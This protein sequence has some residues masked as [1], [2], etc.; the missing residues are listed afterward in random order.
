M[1]FDKPQSRN[2]A[3]L[4]NMLGANNELEPPKSR[5]EALLQEIAGQMPEANPS[6]GTTTG[7]LERLKIG[8][9]I[10]T[11]EGG[12]SGTSDYDALNNKPQI[13]GVTLSGDKSLADLGIAS[14]STVSGILDGTDID[15]FG[16][17]E[18][19]L[20]DKVDKVNG[21]GLSTNDYDDTEKAAVSAATTAIAGIKDGT[22]IDS[23]GDVET[24]LGAIQ[25]GQSIDSFADVESAI[26]A[27]E[28]GTTIDSFADVENALANK[29]NATDNNLDTEAKTIVGAINEHEGDIGSLKSGLTDLSEEV[30]GDATVYPYADV[31]TIEDAVPSNLADCSVKIEPVQD[32]HGQSAPYVGGAGKNKLPLVLADIKAANTGG[33]WNDN[34]Y[35]INSG[36]ITVYTDD[37]GNVTGI[38]AN[39]TFNADSYIIIGTIYLDSSTYILNGCP[40]GGGWSTYLQFISGV[41]GNDYRDI[42]NGVSFNGDS[43]SHNAYIRVNAGTVS[44]LEFL[45]MIRLAT[46]TDATFAPYTNI[47]PI[48][49]HTEVDVQRSRL[50]MLDGLEQGFY[51]SVGSKMDADSQVRSSDYIDVTGG[52][53]YV[54]STD[55]VGLNVY[56]SQYS[57]KDT[58]RITGSNWQSLPYTFTTESNAKYIH[59]MFKKSDNN[60]LSPSEVVNPR[61]DTLS[62]YN[63]I[64]T[65][66]IALGD[67]IYGGTVDFDSGVMTVTQALVDMGMLSWVYD[68]HQRFYSTGISSTVKTPA[69][70]Q[71]V[72]NALCSDYPVVKMA[73]QDD[74][75]LTIATNGTLYVRDSAYTDASDFKTAMDG[76][77][78]CYELATPTTIQLTPQQIQL[79][80]GTNTLTAST[81]QISVT[82][83]G[84]SGAIG[85]V[86][87]QVNEI[88]ADVADVQSGLSNKIGY[89]RVDV[90]GT[91]I[92]SQE[93]GWYYANINLPTLPSG[94]VPISVYFDG[95]WDV[96][97]FYSINMNTAIARCLTSKTIG[98]NNRY[99]RV[100]Y[101]IP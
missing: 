3:I 10:Y 94:A 26:G 5:V 99:I 73:I 41:G 88:A 74:K 93:N 70:Q 101:Y 71:V 60:D 69:S 27:I 96:D 76:V 86:Q 97:I 75:E 61:C 87:E 90:S 83:N 7:T 12:G 55:T 18:T 81:G 1:A 36:T 57:E 2:E 23:F 9:D 66:T 50:N 11:V 80:K 42:G 38:K 39:G 82:V 43:D 77:Q 44:N 52:E 65:Y 21:K 49:G 63:E 51:S 68:V 53:S 19:A 4:Q 31:I 24:A 89:I 30:N 20:G 62:A 6:E 46:E 16:D 32:L 15:S 72:P 100:L 22:T 78:L 98:T 48:S 91:E 29:Q 56:V 84:V 64:Q 35:T 54:I 47:C 33:T 25:D 92:N 79:L 17:V 37:G 85:S 28:D 34:V 58:T 95:G 40:S 8:D 13:A 67:T 59:I 14:A 45:P